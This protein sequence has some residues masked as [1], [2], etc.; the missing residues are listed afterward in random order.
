MESDSRSKS[1]I[2]KL[3]KIKKKETSVGSLFTL[4]KYFK[5][6][7]KSYRFAL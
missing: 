2:A 4:K 7:I 6:Q 1:T 5:F 3:K